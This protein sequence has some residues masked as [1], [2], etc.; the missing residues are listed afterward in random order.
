M[1]EGNLLELGQNGEAQQGRAMTA[2]QVHGSGLQV[3]AGET[4]ASTWEEEDCS[5]RIGRGEGA[6]MAVGCAT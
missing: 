4:P 1:V 6:G 2:A 5:V 3:K